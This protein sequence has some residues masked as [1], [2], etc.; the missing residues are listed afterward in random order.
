VE[1]DELG[2]A[3]DRHAGGVVEHP[4]GHVV[5]LVPLEVP[6]EAGDRC[7]DG[8]HDVRLARHLAEAL[9]PGIVHPELALEVD[10]T[11][12]IAA[13]EQQFDGSLGALAGGHAG[14]ADAGR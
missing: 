4:R 12:R 2:A 10:L 14:R 1:D 9:G 6:H 5:L 11:G 8:E 7:V 13:F 3:R